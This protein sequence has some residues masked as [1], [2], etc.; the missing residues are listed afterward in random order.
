MLAA[1]AGDFL[2]ADTEFAAAAATHERI[3]APMW[4]ART[5]VE[6]ARML[7]ARAEPG[8]RDRAGDLLRPAIATARAL[9]LA[10][11]EREAVDLLSSP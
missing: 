9:G 8:D 6:W 3:R 11:I 2:Q 5:H 4:L 1:T 7:L 10:R